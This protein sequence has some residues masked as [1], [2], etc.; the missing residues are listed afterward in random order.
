MSKHTLVIL[1]SVI[2]SIGLVIIFFGISQKVIEMPL[3]FGGFNSF[4]ETGVTNSSSSVTTVASGTVI[5]AANNG[6]IYLGLTNTGPNDVYLIFDTL[7][8]A[9][10]YMPTGTGILL[11]PDQHYE[12]GPDNL[13]MGGITGRSDT[14]TSTL[15]IIEK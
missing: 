4:G 13:Y 14:A 7:D 1:A 15:T 10:E 12:I 11:A 3:G 2:V 5:V 6:R 8:Q 9:S